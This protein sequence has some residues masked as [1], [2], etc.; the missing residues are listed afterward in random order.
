MFLTSKKNKKITKRFY[1]FVYLLIC[2]YF[3]ILLTVT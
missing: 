3:H 1:M 2:S